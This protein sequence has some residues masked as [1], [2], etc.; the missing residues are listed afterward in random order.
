MITILGLIVALVLVFIEVKPT[1]A[2]HPDEFVNSSWGLVRKIEGELQ[3][4][5]DLNQAAASALT[6]SAQAAFGILRVY[7]ASWEGLYSSDGQSLPRLTQDEITQ[8][9]NSSQSYSLT[10]P[11]VARESVVGYLSHTIPAERLYISRPLY[12][13]LLP[14]RILLAIVLFILITI[15]G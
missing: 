9:I 6:S 14:Y 4:G 12:N 1:P 7:S 10:L 11:I 5:S 8:E 15:L 13:T 2:V 3:T